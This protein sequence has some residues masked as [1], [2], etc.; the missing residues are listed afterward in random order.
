M[1]VILYEAGAYGHY[2]RKLKRV[3]QT[4]DVISQ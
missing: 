3:L 2:Y 4:A 1:S